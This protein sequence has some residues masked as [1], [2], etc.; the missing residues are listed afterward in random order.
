MAERTIVGLSGNLTRPS[1]TRTLVREILDVAAAR[2]IGRTVL[3]DLVDAGPELGAAVHR[4]NLP[5]APEAVI[6]AIEQ[7]DALVVAT[8]VY[9]AAYTGLFKHLFDL[10][11][12]KMLEGR[13]VILAATGGSDRHALVI[14]HHL[15]PLFAFF[16]AHAVPTGLYATSADFTPEGS[17]TETMRARIVPALDQVEGFMHPHWAA[18]PVPALRVV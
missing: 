1:R 9:K 3:Y 12:P 13:P 8:P 6:A 10:I 2:G 11:D 4:G 7:S 17:L 16:R 15:R 5:P 14:E 18:P